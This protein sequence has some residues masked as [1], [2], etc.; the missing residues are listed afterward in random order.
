[1]KSDVFQPDISLQRKKDMMFSCL[2]EC[3]VWVNHDT[4]SINNEHHW[5][6][7]PR[8]HNDIY[9]QTFLPHKMIT[10][11]FATRF[12]CLFAEAR[13]MDNNVDWGIDHPD[14]RFKMNHLKKIYA[15]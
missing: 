5:K 9:K 14:L 2:K 13:A 6:Y 15:E 1:M 8:M 4:C 3:A 7:R 11:L 10:T 12:H